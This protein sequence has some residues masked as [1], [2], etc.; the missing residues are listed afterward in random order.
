MNYTREQKEAIFSRGEDILVSAGAG[1]GK[2][3]V[4]VTRIT[5]MILDSQHPLSADEILVL[6]FTNA[7]A[8]EMK[9]R[10]V[11]EME[12]R[13][14]LAPENSRLRRQIRAIKHADISTIHSFCLHLIRT[15]FN[16]LGL[17]PSFR[18]A[19]EG[20]LKL[21][22][23]EVRE[24]LLE[25]RYLAGEESFH[26]LVEAYAPGK[27]DAVLEDMIE[28][29]YTFSRGFPDK[30]GWFA[31]IDRD[32]RALMDEETEDSRI[33]GIILANARNEI[34]RLTDY[35]E[36]AL[37]L[38]RETG[39]PARIRDYFLME[40]DL[41]S[42]LLEAD[43]FQE[44]H[45]KIHDISF[46]RYPSRDK[47]LKGW[48]PFDRVKDLHEKV[49]KGIEDLRN[50]H[51]LKS[52]SAL[53]LELKQVYPLF[54]EMVSLMM[55]F[56]AM[57]LRKKKEENLYDFNDLEYFALKLLVE[58][59]EED[60]QV[61][62]SAAAREIAS[63]YKAIFV[64]E[65]QDT[66]LVQE[67]LINTLLEAG[68]AGLFAVG[69]VKQSIYRFRQARPDLF[70]NRYHSYQAGE[71]KMIEL[72]DNFRSSPDVLDYC[73]LFFRNLMTEDFGGIDY[74]NK[75]ALRAGEESPMALE[76][77]TQ[78]TLLMVTGEDPLEEDLDKLLAEAVMIG[79]KIRKLHSEGYAYRDMVILLRSAKEEGQL[80]ADCLE[81][82]NIPAVCENYKGYFQTREVSVILNYLSI[83]D[84]VYQD[85]SMAS[86]LLSEI[87]GFT[88]G[89]L[90]DLK[91]LA[92]PAMRKELSL[93]ELMKLYEEEGEDPGL[94]KRIGD[95]LTTLQE[96]RRK[97]QEMP[98]HELVWDI[99]RETGYYE[100][101]L[102]MSHGQKRRKNLT[103]LLKHAQDYEKTG[104]KGLFYFIRHMEQLQSYEVELGGGSMADSVEDLVRITTIHKSKGLEYPVVFVSRL[105]KRFNTQDLSG[106]IL[107][108]PQIGIGMDAI[109]REERISSP[110]ILKKAIKEIIKKETLEEELRILYV[111]MTRAM[112]KLILTGVVEAKKLDECKDMIRLPS[113]EQGR[114][115]LDWILPVLSQAEWKGCSYYHGEDLERILEG[116][117]GSQPVAG[118]DDLLKQEETVEADVDRVRKAFDRSYPYRES[119]NW[120][121]K[122]SVSELKKLAMQEL[123]EEESPVWEVPGT[124]EET[125][126]P[127]FLREGE[128]TL[129]STDYGTM[130]HKL[131]ELLP[132]SAIHS[133]EELD[134]ALDRIW[135]R[136]PGCRAMGDAVRNRV[137]RGIA[138]F[139]FSDY[140]QIF[141]R[142]EE[143]GKLHK[144]LPFT[145]GLDSTVLYPDSKGQETVILQGIIDVCGEDQDGLWLLDYKTDRIKEGEERLLLDRY[146]TQMLYY[147]MALEQIMEKKVQHSLI[148]SFALEKFLILS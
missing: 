97:K 130:V 65:Y 8:R 9:E 58:R 24:K 96:F 59:Y 10:V 57:F 45:D 86:V 37:L 35:V 14:T 74:D 39:E 2:T 36:R 80:L 55:D 117:S 82:L 135:A 73:N 118:L 18:I 34:R 30:E 83:V 99:Y 102:S 7:A 22:R 71:G 90:A 98:L 12:S 51:F 144:E 134:T 23:Q 94:R 53:R 77:E 19:E 92:D 70:L 148:Y 32:F 112:R 131:M 47:T 85:I 72:R 107:Y 42:S 137:Y 16:E 115:Y 44:F 114:S 95:F 120:K 124:E 33:V 113:P 127:A 46:P 129:R 43:S 78:E 41:L 116:L 138:S 128:E 91:T 75:V 109:D 31:R 50:R 106:R 69:D 52:I 147:K 105:A 104:L 28:K 111:A 101:L 81:S 76:H 56:D 67:T 61:I 142:M 143:E 122:Y 60:G 5:E 27:D 89:N 6:T 68:Q 139:L 110:T 26:Q 141:S 133:K 93:Y 4:L 48:E 62:P 11:R 15:H 125:L 79:D 132:F 66:N 13:L 49:K 54:Q 21:M 108:H 40:K 3:R 1:A 123:P 145:L 146:K 38:L 88:A 126:V 136:Q 20:E 119:V 84:N 87:G 17:D 121:R 25:E 29:L 64:D 140:G 103:T 100:R 63:H